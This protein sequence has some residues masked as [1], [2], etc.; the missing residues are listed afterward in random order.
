MLS[1]VKN[2]CLVGCVLLAGCITPPIKYAPNNPVNN[3]RIQSALITY[4]TPASIPITYSAPIGY[5]VNSTQSPA[6]KD[7][8]GKQAQSDARTMLLLIGKQIPLQLSNVLTKRGVKNGGD[9]TISL[10][11]IRAY[12][13]WKGVVRLHLEVAVRTSD[14]T[15]P[16]W[17][18]EIGA[19]GRDIDTGIDPSGEKMAALFTTQIISELARAG[20]IAAE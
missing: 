4:Q 18:M 20:F 2:L 14:R 17:V 6:I 5:S 11:P 19:I 10:R 7:E 8:L 16:Q 12:A 9:A 3:E 15:K 1:I 13:G